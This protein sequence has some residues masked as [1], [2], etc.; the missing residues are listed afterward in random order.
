MEKNKIQF[1]TDRGFFHDG[2]AKQVWSVRSNGRCFWRTFAAIMESDCCSF[3]SRLPRNCNAK[4]KFFGGIQR[5]RVSLRGAV[6]LE[7]SFSRA[8]IV[9]ASG[10]IARKVRVVWIVGPDDD[11]DESP[12]FFERNLSLPFSLSIELLLALFVN[13]RAN[14]PLMWI[15]QQR[16]S[17]VTRK[18][19]VSCRHEMMLLLTA[20]HKKPKC[21]LYIRP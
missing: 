5:T 8:K 13:A 12:L 17:V 19:T 3:G 16:N 9:F 18:G 7:Q 20:L 15:R 6:I 2:T 21:N 1:L 11:D 14:P 4:W 10:L